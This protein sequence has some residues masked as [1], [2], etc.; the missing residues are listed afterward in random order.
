M[1]GLFGLLVL[2]VGLVFPAY[3]LID[4][5]FK[6]KQFDN[7]LEK[8]KQRKLGIVEEP[9]WAERRKAK[10]LSTDVRTSNAGECFWGLSH[11]REWNEKSKHYKGSVTFN[12]GMKR[13]LQNIK[14][15]YN[16]VPYLQRLLRVLGT[17][18]LFMQLCS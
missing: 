16:S 10:E 5:F 13:I 4:R 8:E 18:L 14:H 2:F 1:W 3:M 12:L 6:N 11:R 15:Y 9:D 17:V 7:I